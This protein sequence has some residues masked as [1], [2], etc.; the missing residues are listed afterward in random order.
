MIAITH[1]V[2]ARSLNAIPQIWSVID[3]L[4]RPGKTTGSSGR[5]GRDWPPGLSDQNQTMTKPCTVNSRL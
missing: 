2:K 1:Q 5:G 3:A 4:V